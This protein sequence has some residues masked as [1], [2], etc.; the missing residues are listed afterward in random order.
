[1]QQWI[2]RMLDQATGDLGLAVLVVDKYT[3]YN[4]LRL[5][6]KGSCQ[7]LGLRSKGV[8]DT[9]RGAVMIAANHHLFIPRS[10]PLAH[11]WVP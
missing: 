5:A 9:A 6:G 7:G 10:S 3:E 2:W 4:R 11:P 1:M 8:L